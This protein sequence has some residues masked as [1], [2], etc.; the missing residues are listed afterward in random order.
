VNRGERFSLA[1]YPFV[2]GRSFGWG[3]WQE[4]AAGHRRAVL[5]LIIA[6]HRAPARRRALADDF[7]VSLWDELAAALAGAHHAGGCGPYTPAGRTVARRERGADPAAAR[8][9]RHP[10]QAWPVGR[11][12]PTASCTPAT[13]C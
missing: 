11:S 9:L 3:E 7:V 6:V 2:D 4:S 10:C 13:P 1:L 5:D 8:P 12:S